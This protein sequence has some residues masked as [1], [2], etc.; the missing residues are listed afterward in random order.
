MREHA[1]FSCLP[2]PCRPD[3]TGPASRRRLPRLSLGLSTRLSKD[4]ETPPDLR[5]QIQE[6]GSAWWR[7]GRT[8]RREADLQTRPDER[9]SSRRRSGEY[10]LGARLD[11]APP[12]PR[13]NK[14][15]RVVGE[16]TTGEHQQADGE[17]CCLDH[18][19]VT[20][21]GRLDN[22]RAEAV[23][24]RSA[25]T[26][27]ERVKVVEALRDHRQRP[28]GHL[29]DLP[30]PLKQAKMPRRA[31]VDERPAEL[32]RILP[33]KRLLRKRQTEPRKKAVLDAKKEVFKTALS[34][35][36]QPRAE[37]GATSMRMMLGLLGGQREDGGRRELMHRLVVR[38]SVATPKYSQQGAK[39]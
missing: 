19:V 5:E 26:Y 9:A 21:L 29:G 31:R 6:A 38:D 34:M 24:E 2:V 23:E 30:E 3:N 8:Y 7:R 18:G 10:G 32:P 17:A 27:D 39:H 20:R 16:Q 11:A 15:V 33:G 36:V 28:P 12:N 4:T 35:G 1:R 37:I 14:T 25:L 13:V 22:E